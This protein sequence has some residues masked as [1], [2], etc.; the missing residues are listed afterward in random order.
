MTRR[1]KIKYK[2]IV[3]TALFLILPITSF[4]QQLNYQSGG[5]VYNSENVKQSPKEVRTLL[6]TNSENL[7]LYNSGRKKKTWGNILFYGGLGL[8]ATN[9]IVAATTYNLKQTG[10]Y[11]DPISG[12]YF[13]KYEDKPSSMA[14][15][16]VGGALVAISIPI[17][18]GYPKK[19]K[20]AL[21]NYNS[22]L[23]DNYIPERKIILIAKANQ[24][25]V[26]YQF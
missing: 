19:I 11:Y 22:S 18:I 2:N 15:A 10:Q 24:L 3:I 1:T 12:I 14:F 4:S 9:V 25:G 8:I 6:S 23:T 21:I 7:A 16:I 5:T 20:Q 13:P 26:R 17:K